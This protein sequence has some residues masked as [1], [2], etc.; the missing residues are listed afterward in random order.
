LENILSYGLDF[1]GKSV[2]IASVLKTAPPIT[3]G[4]KPAWFLFVFSKFEIWCNLGQ[5][6]SQ[7]RVRE[8][9]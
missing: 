8:S 7:V 2:M 6:T 9:V 1:V 5:Q 3:P 4:V